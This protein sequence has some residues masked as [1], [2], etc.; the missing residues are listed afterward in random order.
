MK[1]EF[2]H[3]RRH[4]SSHSQHQ[5]YLHIIVPHKGKEFVFFI[6]LPFIIRQM[7]LYI[8]SSERSS[9][10]YRR[11]WL[12][13]LFVFQQKGDLVF[14]EEIQLVV[15]HRLVHNGHRLGAV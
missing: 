6:F 12:N 10:K 1:D 5:C 11:L 3:S 8:L 2:N 4:A 13:Y 15:E 9:K 14:Q 7:I